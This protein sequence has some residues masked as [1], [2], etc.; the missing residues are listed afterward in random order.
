MFLNKSKISNSQL[1]NG[2]LIALCTVIA[3]FSTIFLIAAIDNYAN[4]ED[5][6]AT[7]VLFAFL[8]AASLAVTLIPVRNLKICGLA[9]K[10]NNLFE[11]DPDGVVLMSYAAK[12]FRTDEKGIT[13]K[14]D[15]TVAKGFLQKCSVGE[16]NGQPVFVLSNGAEH[17]HERFKVVKCQHCGDFCEIRVGF[18]Q[19]CPSCGGPVSAKE[20]APKPV[21]NQAPV[22]NPN[23]VQP[24]KA[25]LVPDPGD[26]ANYDIFLKHSGNQKGAVIKITMEITAL[27]YLSC[28]QYVES[29]PIVVQRNVPL[30]AALIIKRRYE[31][32][33]AEVE[34]VTT[35]GIK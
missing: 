22:F 23:A 14:F 3:T 31:A 27:S 4:D 9:N 30:E 12:V 11:T 18:S 34:L 17:P 33:G 25:Y 21:A 8:L 16:H 35:R 20:D 24:S 5:G 13:E 2:A 29:T 1:L 6:A 15:K 19:K 32:A 28:Q 10:F 26:N 7:I